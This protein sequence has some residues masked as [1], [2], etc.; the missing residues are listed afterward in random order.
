MK[1]AAILSPFT[2]LLPS[3]GLAATVQV[4]SS[5]DFSLAVAPVATAV[6]AREL[7]GRGITTFSAVPGYPYIGGADFI[8]PVDLGE[9]LTCYELT[10]TGPS[11]AKRSHNF[12]IID[13]SVLGY[14]IESGAFRELTK[15][16]VGF[17]FVTARKVDASGCGI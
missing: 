8:N 3:M 5:S 2:L 14:R 4:F 6:C 15:Q 11:S 1:F 13:T 7:V 17:A 10:Y 12:T 16:T 9:C